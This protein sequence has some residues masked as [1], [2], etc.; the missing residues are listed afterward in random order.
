MFLF[1]GVA[2]SQ[3]FLDET[4]ENDWAAGLRS[5][6]LQV[7][8]ISIAVATNAKNVSCAHIVWIN[9]HVSCVVSISSS[10]L[11]TGA[12]EISP[13]KSSSSPP[14]LI[15]QT[16]LAM[17]ASCFFLWGRRCCGKAL[18]CSVFLPSNC[19]R[20][21]CS[22]NFESCLRRSQPLITAG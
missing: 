5:K 6:S 18:W 3:I 19:L 16:V 17:F 7:S 21:N 13:P 4:L 2:R 11:W 20:K 14:S 12:P 15:M 10:S 1:R 9:Q 22:E 8:C